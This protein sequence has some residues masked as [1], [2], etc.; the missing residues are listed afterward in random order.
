ML[1]SELIAKL[2]AL[3]AEH[4][5]LEVQTVVPE[6]PY[7][8]L[9]GEPDILDVGYHDDEGEYVSQESFDERVEEAEDEGEEPPELEGPFICIGAKGTD[10]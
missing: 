7:A 10:C 8:R 6:G 4:G 5:D 2:Q 3:Q 9:E 1:V